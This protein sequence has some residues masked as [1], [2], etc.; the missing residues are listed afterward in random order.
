MGLE[1]RVMALETALAQAS[2]GRVDK[3][4]P[5]KSFHPMKA[6]GLQAILRV[7]V[8]MLDGA[9][10]CMQFFD[11]DRQALRLVAAEG[12]AI[13]R[14]SDRPLSTVVADDEAAGLLRDGLTL[15]IEDCDAQIG[16][17]HV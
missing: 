7:A 14:A 15:T 16:R 10:G 1:R 5:Y 3:R 13:D 2:L 12:M 6:A 17:A 9:A 8:Q 4:D 11:V